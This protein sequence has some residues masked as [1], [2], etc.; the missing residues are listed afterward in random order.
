MANGEAIMYM[1]MH[2][3]VRVNH[4]HAQDIVA[5]GMAASAKY[6]SDLE[7]MSQLQR[8]ERVVERCT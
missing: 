8:L 2:V 5:N 4:A 6:A 7:L 1:H 3:H